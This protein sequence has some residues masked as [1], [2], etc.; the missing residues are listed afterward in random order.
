[1]AGRVTT[2]AQQKALFQPSA[3]RS[4]T[5]YTITIPQESISRVIEMLN[6]RKSDVQRVVV[7]ALND[8]IRKV[9][10]E[11]VQRIHTRLNVSKAMIRGA[12]RIW[13]AN[14]HDNSVMFT[15]KKTRRLP[16]KRFKPRQIGRGEFGSKSRMRLDAAALKRDSA[17]TIRGHLR[18]GANPNAG[19]RYKIDKAK[20]P[21]FFPQAFIGGTRLGFHV[22]KREAGAKRLP[23]YQPRALSPWGMFVKNKM[24]AEVIKVGKDEMATLLEKRLQFVLKL[25]SGEIESKGFRR[26]DP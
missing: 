26:L 14:R 10:R 21:G 6:F 17:S 1:M 8:A 12:T 24:D 22:W 15:L 7:G 19:V 5:L 25:R 16:L 20:G 13:T 4:P 23:I 2:A 18:G 9:Q 3:D 11:A